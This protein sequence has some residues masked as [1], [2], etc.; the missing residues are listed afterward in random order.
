MG[1]PAQLSTVRTSTRLTL[2]RAVSLAPRS[3]LPCRPFHSYRAPARQSQ[4]FKL[5]QSRR[6]ASMS[7]DPN[8]FM[9]TSGRNDA[10]WVHNEPYSNRPQFPKLN[11][12]LETD[13]CIIGSGISGISVAEQCV[14]RG[15]NV[16]MLEARDILSGSSQEA[17]LMDFRADLHRRRDWTNLRP[18]SIGSRRWIFGDQGYSRSGRSQIDRRIAR[19][20]SSTCWGGGQRARHRL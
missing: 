12:D 6:F 18:P 20:G 17:R 9:R 10:V 19:L 8:Q 4:I 16:V 5:D 1:S 2:R 13:V 14:R 7:S 3:H 11:N 15:L